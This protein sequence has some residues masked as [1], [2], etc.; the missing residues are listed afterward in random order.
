MDMIEG[1]LNGD[2]RYTVGLWRN[3][4]EQ[5]GIEAMKAA[6]EK[7]GESNPEGKKSKKKK[8]SFFSSSSSKKRQSVDS[9]GNGEDELA[10]L[11]GAILNDMEN[12]SLGK[13][14]VCVKLELNDFLVTLK[15]DKAELG[16]V[17]LDEQCI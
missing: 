13:T 9:G 3:N 8:W 14:V 10:E 5:E 12:Q 1:E 15:G 4:A 11:A 2:V 16:K 7:T 6:A 17:R